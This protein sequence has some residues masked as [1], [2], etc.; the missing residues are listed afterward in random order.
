MSNGVDYKTMC[1]VVMPFGTKPVGKKKLLGAIPWGDREVNFDQIYDQ[2][3]EP[4]IEATPLPEGGN[5][6]PFRTDMNPAVANIDVAMF[7]GLEYARMVLSDI[8]GMN[9]N[10]FYELGARHHARQS[11][12]AIFRQ[13][14]GPIPFDISHIKAV[15]YEYEPVENAKKARETIARVLTESLKLNLID[16]PIQVALQR[17]MQQPQSFQDALRAAE[18]ALRAQDPER[19]IACYTDALAVSPDSALIHFKIGLMHKYQGRWSQARDE[20]ARAAALCPSYADAYREQGIAE[21]KLLKKNSPPSTPTG[22]RALR[23][24]IELNDSDFDAHASLGGLLRREG[25]DRNSTGLLQEALT[26]YGKA[27]TVSLGHPYPLLNELKLRA[28]L[29]GKLGLTEA[30]KFDLARAERFRLQQIN[31]PLPIDSPWSFFDLS[32]IR[33]YLGSK[34]D[35]LKYLNEGLLQPSTRSWQA[36][37]HRETL[38]MIQSGGYDPPGLADGIAL[39]RLAESRLPKND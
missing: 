21:N 10:V 2:I 1:F 38:E 19:A 36:T 14:D 13:A 28:K 22:E 15:P 32:E 3:F 23:R 16:S 7:N 12:T 24:A 33:L 17:Q 20:F 5:L 4:A 37:T 11:G 31:N 9:P 29:E 26:E 35:F 27:T 30:T 6:V 34:D 25:L 18:D 39:L 8:T